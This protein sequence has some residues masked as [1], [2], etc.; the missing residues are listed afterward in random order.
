MTIQFIALRDLSSSIKFNY[1][2]FIPYVIIE[3]I[4]YSLLGVS[5]NI[6]TLIDLGSSTGGDDGLPIHISLSKGFYEKTCRVLSISADDILNNSYILYSDSKKKESAR[7][8]AIVFLN[9]DIANSIDDLN[10]LCSKFRDNFKNEFHKD[11]ESPFCSNTN[12][13]WINQL[14]FIYLARNTTYTDGTLDINMELIRKSPVDG[15]IPLPESLKEVYNISSIRGEYPITSTYNRRSNVSPYLMNYPTMDVF[16]QN[17]LTD[18]F[19]VKTD[20]FGLDF[21]NS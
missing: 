13:L 2:S 6:P 15:K 18:A 19:T 1:V 10:F 16:L 3:N 20:F 21:F 4:A 9:I 12:L 7:S 17:F 11:E 5:R 8:D 14:N